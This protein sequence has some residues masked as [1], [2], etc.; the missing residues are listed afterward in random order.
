[1]N[2]LK[3]GRVEMLESC[4]K[5]IEEVSLLYNKASPG[6]TLIQSA[7][8]HINSLHHLEAMTKFDDETLGVRCIDEKEK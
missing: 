1:M 3:E 8:G 4:I 6:W 2:I 7:W 5:K